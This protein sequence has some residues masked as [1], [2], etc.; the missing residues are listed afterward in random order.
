MK[1]LVIIG[2]I[3]TVLATY[4]VFNTEKSIS[5]KNV[6]GV[7]PAGIDIAKFILNKALDQAGRINPNITNRVSGTNI[8]GNN[9]LQQTAVERARSKMGEIGNEITSRA[10][11]LIKK[12]IEN[13]ANRLFCSPK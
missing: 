4:F 10:V 5:V 6:N 9:A 1:T 7:V 11:D 12:P 3:L 2:I 8:L 13:T